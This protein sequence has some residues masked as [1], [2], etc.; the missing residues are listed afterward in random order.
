MS[1]DSLKADFDAVLLGIG[2]GGV[3]ALR[4]EGEDKDNVRDAVDFIADL[5]QASDL[6]TIPVG[7]RVVVIGGGMTAV[8]AAVQS[9]LLGADEVTMVYRRGKERMSASEFEQELATS[10]GVRIIYNAAPVRVTGNGVAQA[11]EFA[12]THDVNGKLENTGETFTVAADQV[13]KP[14]ARRWTVRP[15]GWS[16]KAVKSRLTSSVKRLTQPFGQAAIVPAAG[17]T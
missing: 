12:C 11:V 3:N 7:R 4:A 8:D 5:R 2:L 1:I 6:G 9:K 17:M 13:F 16:L 15:M 14:S 10:K